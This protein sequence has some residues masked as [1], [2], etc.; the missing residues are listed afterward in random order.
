MA[1]TTQTAAKTPT[2]TAARATSASGLKFTR[3]FSKAG[4]SPFD[5]VEW[6]L[7]TA[8]IKDEAARSSSSRRTARSPRAGPTATNVVASKYFYGEINTPERETSVRAARPSGRRDDRRLGHKGRLLRLRP[9]T[10]TPSRRTD[11]PL[12]P[13]VVLQ[14]ARLVQRRLDQVS[15]AG[16]ANNWRWDPDTREVVRHDRYNYPQC[17]ACFIHAVDDM[18]DI[19]RLATTEAMLFKCGS[20]P[21]PTSRPSAPA[22]RSPAAG[23]LRPGLLHE[24]FDAIAAVIKSGGKTRRAAKMGS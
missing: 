17:S 20:A 10:P 8:E 6:E 5:E 22:E 11:V 7:R 18:K 15:P 23:S 2:S 19:M 4:A 21:G 12:R 14:L 24:G 9:T 1:E 3:K 16:A 13:A